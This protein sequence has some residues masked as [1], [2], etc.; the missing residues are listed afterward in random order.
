M[1]KKPCLVYFDLP[2]RSYFLRN[3][4]RAAHMD[5]D[6]KRVT[7]EEHGKMK[8]DKNSMLYTPFGTGSLP[9]LRHGDVTLI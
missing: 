3:I 1:D 7:F 5:F 2:G 6:D 8:A 4:F 9:M